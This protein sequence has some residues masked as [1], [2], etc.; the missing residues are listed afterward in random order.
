M[1]S[2]FA[3][4]LTGA[5]RRGAL[6]LPP[7]PAASAP[8]VEI[9]IE[10]AEVEEPE[11]EGMETADDIPTVDPK[12]IVGYTGPEERCGTCTHFA[13]G[14]CGL[15]NFACDEGGHCMDHE[16]GAGAGLAT[17]PPEAAAEPPTEPMPE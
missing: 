16:A 14:M 10:T 17:V 2:P 4:N 7:K 3:D 8:K 5:R 11:A 13:D 1:A 15:H 6:G 9:E 12:I